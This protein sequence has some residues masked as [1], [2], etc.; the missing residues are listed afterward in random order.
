MRALIL[1]LAVCPVC[2]A[3]SVRVRVVDG[4]NGHGLPKQAVSVQFL[5]E[6]PAKASPP[7]HLET[8]SNGEAEFS[9]PEPSPAHLSVRVAL[10]SEHWHCGCLMMADTEAV[11]HKGFLE[12][13][14]AKT[15]VP[16]PPANAEP[17]YIVFVARPFT[18]AERLLHPLLKE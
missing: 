14:P 1:M 7:L 13:M 9:I 8:D 11:V 6:K 4:K 18:F 2:Y 16:T 12:G 3:Q 5:Y 10:T 15:K 17:G